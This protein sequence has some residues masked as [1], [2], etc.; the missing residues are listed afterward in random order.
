MATYPPTPVHSAFVLQLKTWSLANVRA[1]DCP[2]TPRWTGSFC[3]F[4]LPLPISHLILV[5]ANGVPRDTWL[6]GAASSLI[7]ASFAPYFGPLLI[8]P[9][10]LVLWIASASTFTLAKTFCSQLFPG[11]AITLVCMVCSAAS[12]LTPTHFEHGFGP[13]LCC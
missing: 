5:P 4:H 6:D 12:A 13:C 1:K 9:K 3:F 10:T 11:L 2:K 7:L 8:C